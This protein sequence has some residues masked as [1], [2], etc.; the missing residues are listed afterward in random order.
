MLP[1][2]SVVFPS[3]VSVC[4]R[5]ES[6]STKKAHMVYQSGWQRGIRRSCVERNGVCTRKK[7]RFA[8]C[9]TAFSLYSGPRASEKEGERAEE[10]EGKAVFSCGSIRALLFVGGDMAW[11]V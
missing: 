9:E 7:A 5:S 3:G 11:K 10:E 6:A 2:G 8:L 4:Q 1:L